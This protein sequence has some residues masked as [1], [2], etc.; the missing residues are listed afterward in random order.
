[1]TE[2]EIHRRDKQF[3]IECLSKDLIEMLIADYGMSMEKAM[4]S[5]FNSH[6]YEK[7]E[8][9]NTALYY[10]GA[11]YVMDFLQDELCLHRSVES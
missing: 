4:D 5:L 11:V 9:E 8:D 1:M 3:L 2:E 6:T 7:I 10:Q